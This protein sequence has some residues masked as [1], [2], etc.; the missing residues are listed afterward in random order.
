MFGV[1]E[2]DSIDFS[3]VMETSKSSVRKNIKET[4]TF[5]KYEGIQPESVSKLESKS[6]A[7]HHDEFLVIL[8]DEAWSGPEIV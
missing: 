4:Q 5:V 3:Q 2:L 7:Y 8:D 1:R 6:K